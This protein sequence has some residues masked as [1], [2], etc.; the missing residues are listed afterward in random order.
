MASNAQVAL[1]ATQD[2]AERAALRLIGQRVSKALDKLRAMPWLP[3]GPPPPT[4]S[5]YLEEL[6]DTLQ[7]G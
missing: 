4:R 3:P 6:V 7:V 2:V 5:P 1:R